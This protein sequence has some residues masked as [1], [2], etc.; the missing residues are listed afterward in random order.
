V[1]LD[2][3]E[4]DNIEITV[5]S[6]RRVRLAGVR[7]H[8]SLVTGPGHIASVAGIPVTSVARTICDLTAA[9]PWWT[10]RRALG[11]AR[12]R[13]LVT[14]PQLERTFRALA[15]KGRRRSTVMR[16]LLAR[17]FEGFAPGGSDQEVEICGWIVAAGLPKPVQQH[18]I[19]LGKRNIRVD[20]AYPDL[21]IAVEY[22]GWESHRGRN[23]FDDDRARDNQLEV[24]GWIVLRFTSAS[25]RAAVVDTVREAIEA[26]TA[27]AWVTPPTQNGA[28]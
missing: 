26:R 10:V 8:R 13:G 19:R 14:V 17:E 12:R 11:D 7:E 2:G 9:V 4:P 3:F 24:R 16:M 22:D 1:G 23:P 18:R 25:T 5:P 6:R 15:T 27:G 28:E 21:K 20:A